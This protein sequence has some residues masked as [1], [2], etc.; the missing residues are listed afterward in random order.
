VLG[1]R[2]TGTLELS[3]SFAGPPCPSCTG[4]GDVTPGVT[5]YSFTDGHQTLTEANSTG[6]FEL[7]WRGGPVLPVPGERFE[8]NVIIGSTNGGIRSVLLNNDRFDEAVLG[9]GSVANP[10]AGPLEQAGNYGYN[11]MLDTCFPGTGF[12]TWTAQTVPEPATLTL[13]TTALLGVGA[14]VW[15][16]QRM[17]VW[18]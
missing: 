11:C 13:L 10:G 18:R 16:R 3:D 8:W 12:P 17:G 7:K 1:D 9:T 14:G 15:R 6:S 5:R 4:I 2:I